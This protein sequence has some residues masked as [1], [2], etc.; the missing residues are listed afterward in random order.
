MAQMLRDGET[1]QNEDEKFLA[2]HNGP[3][4]TKAPDLSTKSGA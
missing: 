1:L 4:K 3:T 2:K